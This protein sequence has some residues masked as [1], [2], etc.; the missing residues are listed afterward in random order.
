[1]ASPDPDIVGRAMRYLRFHHLNAPEDPDRYSELS[2]EL[3][4]EHGPTIVADGWW[5]VIITAEWW[6][7]DGD[8]SVRVEVPLQRLM[9]SEYELI[10]DLTEPL[11]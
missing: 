3:E 7:T 11:W 4:R 6:V 8:V 5:N 10:T 1:M 9:S 2:L